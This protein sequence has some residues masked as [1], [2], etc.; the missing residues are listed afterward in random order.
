MEYKKPVTMVSVCV[1][2]MQTL[3]RS[4]NHNI[5]RDKLAHYGVGVIE[6]NWFKTNLTNLYLQ[7][8]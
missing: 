7:K 5:L 6:N 2:F 1:E 3:T 4:F 8:Y